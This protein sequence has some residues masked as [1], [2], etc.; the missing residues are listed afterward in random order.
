MKKFVILFTLVIFSSALL[1]AAETSS[2]TLTASV[3]TLLSISA[4]ATI[5]LGVLTPGVAKATTG[6]TLTARSNLRSW[7]IYAYALIGSLTEYDATEYSAETN[8]GY[9]EDEKIPYTLS[10]NSGTAAAVPAGTA[11]EDAAEFASFTAKTT[12]GING[13]TFPFVITAGLEGTTTWQAGS[14]RDQITF[15]I[16]A[17]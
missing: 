16:S 17:N 8:P 9:N 15:V 3:A 1:F 14:Y 11:L 7:K 4:P 5:D 10:V 12:G 2:S 13:Q 6:Q